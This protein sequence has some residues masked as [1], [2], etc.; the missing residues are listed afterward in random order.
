MSYM[1]MWTIVLIAAIILEA[2]TTDLVTIWFALGA[3]VAIGL[4]YLGV[5]FTIQIVVFVVVSAICIVATRPIAKKYLRTNT[6]KTNLDRVI[7]KHCL[8]TT[9]ITPDAHGEVK[10]MGNMWSAA[11]LDNAYIEMG[12]YAEVVSIE[13]SHLVVKKIDKEKGEEL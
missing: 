11:G 4:D 13:G 12:S 3:L 10:V 5:G 8:V 6:T 9:T 7:G 1:L 2:I